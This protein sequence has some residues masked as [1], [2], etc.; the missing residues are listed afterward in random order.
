MLC[1][2]DIE[3]LIN[4]LVYNGLDKYSHLLTGYVGDP[5]V[6]RQI[7][8]VSNKYAVKSSYLRVPAI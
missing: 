7:G 8:N 5:Q 1:K 3:E 6:L 4:G 2:N